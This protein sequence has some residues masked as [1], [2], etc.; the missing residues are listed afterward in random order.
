MGAL[1]KAGKHAEAAAVMDE[2]RALKD[3]LDELDKTA[4]ALDEQLRLSLARV[5]NLTRDEVPVGISEADNKIVKT[6][7][8]RRNSTSS[9][10]RTGRSA[11]RSAFSI[12]SA[13]Q[14]SAVR[15]SPSTW[16]LGAR[17]NVR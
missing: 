10:S 6:W 13:Q 1:K 15:A 11:K 5:P 2:T 12:W 16:A 9:P 7:G 8:E 17:S 4:A 3:K 14:S